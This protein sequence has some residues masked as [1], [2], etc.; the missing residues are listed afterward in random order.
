MRRRLSLRHVKLGR[1]MSVGAVALA[2]MAGLPAMAAE[3][4][5]AGKRG[6]AHVGDPFA[7]YNTE[8]KVAA[9]NVLHHV[10]VKAAA[11]PSVEAA[12]LPGLLRG[13]AAR[14]ERGSGL[15]R[16]RVARLLPVMAPILRKAGVPTQLAAVVLVESGGDPTALSPKGARGLWQLMPKT[17]REYGLTVNAETDQRLDVVRSTR[18]AA[19]YLRDLYAEFG[20]WKLALAAYN[21]GDQAVKRALERSGGDAFATAARALP[22]ETRNYVPSV[23]H[24]LAWFGGPGLPAPEGAA[25]L[26]RVAYAVGE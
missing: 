21:A 24:A 10:E 12:R 17:A 13:Q 3:H 11:V 15:A 2:L 6:A 4:A 18:A 8:L 14:P 20:S 9:S 5:A 19:E 26:Q 1:A 25:H 23:F 7:S 16:E 22:A